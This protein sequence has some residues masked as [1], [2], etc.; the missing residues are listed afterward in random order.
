[1]QTF[2]F[3]TSI[4]A[5]KLFITVILNLYLTSELSLILWW[6]CFK[7]NYYTALWNAWFWLVSRDIPR[8]VIPR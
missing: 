2:D 6:L 1:M 3:K 4:I 5:I 8:Y 7:L